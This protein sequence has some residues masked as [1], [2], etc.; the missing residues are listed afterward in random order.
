MSSCRCVFVPPPCPHHVEC[1]T[2][3]M[4]A[5]IVVC[6]PVG[7]CCSPHRIPAFLR[8]FVLLKHTHPHTEQPIPINSLY[9]DLFTTEHIQHLSTQI[10]D[11]SLKTMEAC[12]CHRI[13]KKEG[14]CVKKNK[15]PSVH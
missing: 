10:L 4:P 1:T 12:F 9:E 3:Q 6:I 2:L 14:N 5:V 15:A 13:I 8:C 7:Y 11:I